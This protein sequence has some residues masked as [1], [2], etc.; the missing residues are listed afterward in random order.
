MT[1]RSSIAFEA[2]RIESAARA[3]LDA[4]ERTGN[5]AS[6]MVVFR[7]VAVTVSKGQTVEEIVEAHDR[8]LAAIVESETI[9]PLLSDLPPRRGDVVETLED[10]HYTRIAKRTIGLVTAV[11]AE[12]GENPSAITVRFAIRSVDYEPADYIRLRHVREPS[13]S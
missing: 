10:D 13:R 2:R 7:G 6:T 3:A 11:T 5:G 4:M 8:M 9:H 1:T 12:D